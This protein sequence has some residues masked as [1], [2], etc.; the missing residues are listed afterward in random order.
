[1][2]LS[3]CSQTANGTLNLVFQTL[4]WNLRAILPLETLFK[5]WLIIQF[6]QKIR[7]K[8]DKFIAK[9][10]AGSRLSPHFVQSRPQTSQSVDIDKNRPTNS[11][12]PIHYSWRCAAALVP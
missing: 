11:S 5:A 3:V 1:M 12:R 6:S 10:M 8:V 7:S 4:F 9:K 2:N